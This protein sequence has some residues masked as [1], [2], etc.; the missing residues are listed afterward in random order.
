MLNNLDTLFF[1]NRASS[2]FY[3]G[4]RLTCC[5]NHKKLIAG[6]MRTFLTDWRT[7]GGKFRRPKCW[8]KNYAS[9][10]ITWGGEVNLS[11]LQHFLKFVLKIIIFNASFYGLLLFISWAPS[12]KVSTKMDKNLRKYGN[13]VGGNW[14]MMCGVWTVC[15]VLMSSKI[16]RK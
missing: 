16:Y 13:V 2:L 4:N 12:L 1:Q 6:S 7:D 3:I 5:K 11:T 9:C 8:S 15:I 14:N 10:Q